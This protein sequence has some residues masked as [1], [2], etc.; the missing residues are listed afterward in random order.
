MHVR[1]MV[2]RGATNSPGRRYFDKLLG[3]HTTIQNTADAGQF[4]AAALNYAD[5]I[6]LLMRQTGQHPKEV[7]IHTTP[8]FRI[9]IYID[10][11]NVYLLL[12]GWGC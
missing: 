4:F 3:G 2:R 5:G 1:S 8:Q 9:D 7:H 10:I 11:Y 6:D 12:L